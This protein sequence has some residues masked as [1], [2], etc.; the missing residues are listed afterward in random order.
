MALAQCGDCSVSSVPGREG[1]EAGD[2]NMMGQETQEF[3]SDSQTPP[4]MVPR[5]QK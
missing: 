2:L 1:Q 4:A 5:V 3:P